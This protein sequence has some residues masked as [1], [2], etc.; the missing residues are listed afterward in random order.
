MVI[1]QYDAC[2]TLFAC[3]SAINL[4]RYKMNFEWNENDIIEVFCSTKLIS[5][6]VI[7]HKRKQ[8]KK[9]GVCW[10]QTY[11]CEWIER[12]EISIKHA[13]NYTINDTSH[14]KV[15]CAVHLR[16]EM[17]IIMRRRHRFIL[18]HRRALIDN[19]VGSTLWL[20]SW[21]IFV[22]F[23]PISWRIRSWIMCVCVWKRER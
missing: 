20:V 10:I 2:R 11:V 7:E 16:I 14:H 1:N 6:W 13:K 3:I 18:E 17:E 22:H 23:W 4:C 19:S 9:N 5:L 21:R 8:E 15:H 12:K